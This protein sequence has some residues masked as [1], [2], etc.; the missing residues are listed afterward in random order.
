MGPWSYFQLTSLHLAF[1]KLAPSKFVA[2]ESRGRLLPSQIH[3]QTHPMFPHPFAT[4]NP[5][6]PHIFA[7]KFAPKRSQSARR[8]YPVKAH[9]VLT[10]HSNIHSD[11]HA[12]ISHGIKLL[13]FS[14]SR[15]SAVDS[16]T[17]A[18]TKNVSRHVIGTKDGVL[19]ENVPPALSIM[20][21][22]HE[23]VSKLWK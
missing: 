10:D 13:R 14:R 9:Y 16:D 23:L 22:S 3:R 15:A 6:S 12:T 11:A 17:K 21:S 8:R 4:V 18:A 5:M 19:S 2:L 1:I 7:T 20:M